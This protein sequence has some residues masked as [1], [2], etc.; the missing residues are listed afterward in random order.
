MTRKQKLNISCKPNESGVQKYSGARVFFLYLGGICN[1][2]FFY[3]NL[4]II[5]VWAGF[6]GWIAEYKLEEGGDWWNWLDG[7]TGVL[8]KVATMFIFSLAFRFNQCYS[9][10][11]EGRLLWGDVMQVVIQVSFVARTAIPDAGYVDR[12]LRYCIA[13]PYVLKASSRGRSITDPGE[14]G[15]DLIKRGVLTKEEFEDMRGNPCWE[16]YYLIDLLF[17]VISAAYD[18]RNENI[19]CGYEKE[20]LKLLLRSVSRLGQAAGSIM[21]LRSA[22]LPSGYDTV[23][24]GFFYVYF[25]VAPPAWSIRAGLILPLYASFAAAVIMIVML[26][27]SQMLDPFG[28]DMADLPLDSFCEATEVQVLEVDKRRRERELLF[29]NFVQRSQTNLGADDFEV[30][31][32]FHQVKASFRLLQEH[33]A[34]PRKRLLSVGETKEESLA[35]FFQNES[36]LST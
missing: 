22:K 8:D 1:N 19:K 23:H 27:G 17:S 7:S 34:H 14:S 2:T 9:R 6:W 10:W 15:L 25:L 21:S 33:D 30:P 35:N 29:D 36:P 11:W 16:P 32:E 18:K 24:Y 31:F 3:T 28:T 20:H 26:L 12:L 13:F 4:I 5:I